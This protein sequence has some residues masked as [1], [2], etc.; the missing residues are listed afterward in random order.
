MRA[1]ANFDPHPVKGFP[2][3]PRFVLLIPG[4]LLAFLVSGC[5]PGQRDIE[6]SIRTEMKSKMGVN[7]TSI[8]LKKQADGSFLGTATAENGDVYDVTTG[9]PK[10]NKI[11][12]KA[13]PGPAM[14]ERVVRGGMEQQLSGKVK[15]LQLT[16]NG[17][18]NYTGPAELTDGRKVVV[19]TRME[20]MNLVW[21]AKP[22]NP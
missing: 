11:E 22:A 2:M 5:G 9:P 21:E 15:T 4:V 1:E 18:G 6:K 8:D 10:G 13:L 14:V 17:P 20:G 3:V 7:M 16:K 12:W 19:T